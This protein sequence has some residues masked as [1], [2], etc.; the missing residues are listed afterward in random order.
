MG[1]GYHVR[2]RYKSREAA[3]AVKTI[4]KS[5]QI[6]VEAAFS[7]D[8][9]N[10]ELNIKER[11]PVAVDR[12]EHGRSLGLKN[13]FIHDEEISM[14]PSHMK[15]FS[16]EALAENVKIGDPLTMVISIDKQENYGL[17]VMSCLVRDGLGWGEQNLLRYG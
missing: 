15:I 9:D 17:R 8:T 2:C 13:S 11:E 3:A 12:R 10:I 5:D 4:P 1:R 7:D 6:N 16:K 14:P